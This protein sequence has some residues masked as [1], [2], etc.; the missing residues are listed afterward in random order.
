MRSLLSSRCIPSESIFLHQSVYASVCL[1]FPICRIP[2][3]CSPFMQYES[4]SVLCTSSGHVLVAFRSFSNVHELARTQAG[5]NYSI[6][7][8]HTLPAKIRRMTIANLAGSERVLITHYGTYSHP[9][10]AVRSPP[11][12]SPLT[13]FSPRPRTSSHTEEDVY[14]NENC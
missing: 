3:T 4:S 14:G 6:V 11:V 13:A 2:I 10:L 9:R 5:G 8:A 12:S 7:R 1:K